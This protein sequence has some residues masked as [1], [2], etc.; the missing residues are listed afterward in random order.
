MEIRKIKRISQGHDAIDGAGVYLRRVLGYKTAEDFDPFLMLDSFDSLDPKD[1]INGFPFHPHRGIETVTYL[2]S[3]SMEHQDSLGN[4]GMIKPGGSQWMNSGS[5]IMHA[6]M[7]QASDYML[8]FQLWINLPKE[9]KMSNPTYHELNIGEEI[10]MVQDDLAKINVISGEYKGTK[11]FSPKYV[12]ATILDIELEAKSTFTYTFNK[13]E[14]AFVFLIKN[15]LVIDQQTV[16][17]KDAVLLQDGDTIEVKSLDKPARFALLHAL[18]LKE[19][20][21]WNGPIVM[22]TEEEIKQA[23]KD[24]NEGTFIKKDA[25]K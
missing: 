24:L 18:P 14:N 2:I 5:G 7:P 15:D 8:G 25:A 10:K 16:H 12:Q 17:E 22:N 19:S 20:I 6:E 13:E 11:G 21:A 4:K 1:Y 23:M 3:G 9:E